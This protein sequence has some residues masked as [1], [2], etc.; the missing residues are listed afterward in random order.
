MSPGTTDAGMV[1]HLKVEANTWLIQGPESH[2]S[3][4]VP[5]LLRDMGFVARVSA[6]LRCASEPLQRGTPETEAYKAGLDQLACDL[7][8]RLTTALLSPEARRAVS[9]RLVGSP[10]GRA[11][12]T[13]RVEGGPEADQVL[14]LPWELLMP[15]PGRFAVYEAQLDLVRDAFVEGASELPEPIVW[16]LAARAGGGALKVGQVRGGGE[17]AA[18]IARH[19]G[20]GAGEHPPR[21]LSHPRESRRCA[22]TADA[23]AGGRSF[24]SARC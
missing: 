3:A 13:L 9:R 2:Q 24:R 23:S 18:A 19:S 4:Q 16:S 15:E 20:E 7:G 14:A 6:F 21:S 5:S 1:L 17:A 10:S 8:E 22:G 12:L 11:R